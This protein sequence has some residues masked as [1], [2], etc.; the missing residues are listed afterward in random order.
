MSVNAKDLETLASFNNAVTHRSRRHEL[1]AK[2]EYTLNT[3]KECAMRGGTSI[4]VSVRDC[5]CDDFRWLM[6]ELGFK[7]NVVTETR[8]VR[9]I[10]VGWR[11]C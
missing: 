1:E 2:F 7:H 4:V 5:E 10:R 8:G 9:E 3:F 6:T 11:S